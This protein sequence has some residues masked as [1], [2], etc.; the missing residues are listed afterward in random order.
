[1]GKQF[2]RS[3][4]KYFDTHGN[5]LKGKDGYPKIAKAIIEYKAD[6]FGKFKMEFDEDLIFSIL[7][8]YMQAE[9]MGGVFFENGVAI[10]DK[11]SVD[12]HLT[13]QFYP[14]EDQLNKIKNAL[15][16]MNNFSDKLKKILD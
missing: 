11:K 3:G 6:G 16:L 4:I 13:N 15:T 7:N 14:P 12:K 2:R 8:A 9:K 10:L 5:E 1:M